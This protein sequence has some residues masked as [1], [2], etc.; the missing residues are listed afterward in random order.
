[1][2]TLDTSPDRGLRLCVAQHDQLANGINQRYKQPSVNGPRDNDDQRMICKPTDPS[3]NYL[4]F[5]SGVESD[6]I[7]SEPNWFAP[8]PDGP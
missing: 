4:R 7:S 8:S 5:K 2:L 1:M 3:R 6:A